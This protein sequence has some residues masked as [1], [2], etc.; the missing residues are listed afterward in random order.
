LKTQT[1]KSKVIFFAYKGRSRG[2]ADENVDAI[3]R[4]I[5]D[6]NQHQGSYRAVSWEEYRKTTVISKDILEAIT[7][8]EVFACDMTYFNHNVMFELG[9]AIA[10]NK[11]ILIFLNES[12]GEARK[13][14]ESSLFRNI[15]YTSL[16]NHNDVH[17]ALQNGNYQDGILRAIVGPD[18]FGS[19]DVALLCLQGRLENEASLELHSSL[20]IFAE[21][22]HVTLLVDDESTYQQ[23]EW[24]S[25]KISRAH[26]I[27]IHFFNKVVVGSFDENGK[28]SFYAGLACGLGKAVRLVAPSTFRA[29]L[30]YHDILCEYDTPE[31]LVITTVEWLDSVDFAPFRRME[32]KQD[33]RETNLLRIRIGAE[34]AEQEKENLLSYFVETSA[35]IAAAQSDK[36]LVVGTKGSGKSAMYIKLSADFSQKS[37]NFIVQL[38]PESDELLEQLDISGL[39]KPA[40]KMS[41][42]TTV[43]KVVIFSRLVN[44][45]CERLLARSGGEYTD[46]ENRIIQFV[47]K[48]DDL[49]QLSFAGILKRILK[50][51]D[52]GAG[53]A[54]GLELLYQRFLNP[55]KKMLRDYWEKAR[56]K[57]IDIVILADNLDKTWDA[58]KNIE[59]QAEM[60]LSLMDIENKLRQEIFVGKDVQVGI[61]Q[62]VF[63]RRDIFDYLLEY[64]GEPDKLRALAK[65][66]D[67][68]EHPALLKKLLEDRFRHWLKLD[69]DASVEQVWL[70]YFEG[71]PGMDPYA[72]IESVIVRRPRDAVFFT[73]ALFA[74]AFDNNHIRVNR[75]DFLASMK[76]YKA[77]LRDT[78]VAEIGPQFPAVSRVL[79]PLIQSGA[80]GLEWKRL[81]RTV[82]DCA[83][84]NV[85]RMR[86]LVEMLEKHGFVK[87]YSNGGAE[88]G[89]DNAW[90]RMNT[91]RWFFFYEKVIL[92]ADI[93]YI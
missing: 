9:Y 42:F 4:A 35:F 89:F 45:I 64:S 52:R 85:S 81:R 3:Q 33:E 71:Q 46:V 39:Y 15:R 10:K 13:T 23:L 58:K 29:P 14:Y 90:R 91:R 36:C 40:A 21:R 84:A 7:G 27:V 30:D 19:S 57:Y 86:R 28:N 26:A 47:E 18:D 51:G 48:N 2:E 93:R 43:W 61:R 11:K 17:V 25:Q 8:C 6:Y 53:N 38:A 22:E 65:T 68:N 44:L 69:R 59:I 54:D 20:Q 88:L 56:S 16:K 5:K 24:Y 37:T 72:Q 79:H 32:K 82:S 76:S 63:L 31:S 66:I 55:L 73:N 41:Y 78:L 70:D 67:W 92:K 75:A 77:F 49:G 80:I 12:I 83:G 50:E 87:F 34:Q 1:A 62:I 60:L 74:A